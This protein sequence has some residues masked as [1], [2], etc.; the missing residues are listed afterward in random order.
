MQ[1][2]RLKMVEKPSCTEW[3]CDFLEGTGKLQP[4]RIIRAEALKAGFGQSELKIARKN[5]GIVLEPE[6]M[7]SE[8]SGELEDYWRLP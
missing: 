8:V 1:R 6:F 2:R 4:R 3:L 7:V 5:L